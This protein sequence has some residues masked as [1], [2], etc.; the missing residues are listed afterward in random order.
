MIDTAVILAAG[1]GSRLR[2]S[3]RNNTPKPLYHINGLCLINRVMSSL[4]RAGIKHFITVLG[5]KSSYLTKMTPMIRRPGTTIRFAENKRWK[6]QKTGISLLQAEDLVRDQQAFICCMGDHLVEP[7]IIKKLI[8]FYETGSPW[9]NYM[10]ID[11]RPN[12]PPS[13]CGT[14]VHLAEQNPHCP[15]ILGIGRKLNSYN[16]VDVGMFIFTHQIFN[17]ILKIEEL[18]DNCDLCEAVDY[19]TRIYGI[20]GVDVSPW[21]WMNIN[22]KESVEAAEANKYLCS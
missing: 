21:S 3:T 4:H 6:T 5:Y 10:A 16:A 1:Q 12:L 7:E 22:D 9:H 15:L 19:F 20:R 11:Q 13:A 17:C 14:K 8:R 2:E 18:T